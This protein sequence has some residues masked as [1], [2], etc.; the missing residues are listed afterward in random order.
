MATNK[1]IAQ[2]KTREQL[3]AIG[4]SYANRIAKRKGV[5]TSVHVFEAMRQ[6]GI[7]L[8]GH[9]PR[10]MGQ[11]FRATDFKRVRF[12]RLGSHGRPVSVW[13]HKEA[14]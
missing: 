12:A 3:I 1:S 2:K 6:A 11:V 7:D 8:S 9:D 10:W 4:I 14:A 5:V 13:A